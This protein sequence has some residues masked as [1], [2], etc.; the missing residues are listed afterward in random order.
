M[1]APMRKAKCDCGDEADAPFKG[2]VLLPELQN[3][4][5]QLVMGQTGPLGHD[6]CFDGRH[7]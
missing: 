4:E 2:L 6:L 3:F 1:C 7:P 5:E